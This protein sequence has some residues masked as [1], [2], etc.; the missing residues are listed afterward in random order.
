M[1][2][3]GAGLSQLL[4]VPASV[5]PVQGL[6]GGYRDRLVVH[7]KEKVGRR[8]AWSGRNGRTS[9]LVPFGATLGNSALVS[10]SW[11]CGQW[12]MPGGGPSQSVVLCFACDRPGFG[13]IELCTAATRRPRSRQRRALGDHLAGAQVTI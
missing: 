1:A 11:A 9:L 7:G 2:L 3:A 10:D 13:M 12:R 5:R 6:Y 4:L 8:L